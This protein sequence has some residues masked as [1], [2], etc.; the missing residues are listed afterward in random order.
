MKR[1]HPK[2]NLLEAPRRH[3]PHK[4]AI[5]LKQVST[6]CHDP[7]LAGAGEAV[8]NHGLELRERKQVQLDS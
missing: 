1:I 2:D 4:N 3:H 8:P 7:R 6:A 5:R